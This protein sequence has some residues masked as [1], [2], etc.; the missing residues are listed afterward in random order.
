FD[1]YKRSKPYNPALKVPTRDHPLVFNMLGELKEKDSLVM[2]YKD[3]YEYIRSVIHSRSMSDDL[4]NNIYDAE[5]FIFLGMPFDKWY[6]HLFMHLLHQH[7]KGRTPKF[8]ANTFLDEKIGTL[9]DEQYMM[10][11]VPKEIDIEVFVRTLYEK[12]AEYGMLRGNGTQPQVELPKPALP[13]GQLREWIIGNDFDSLF[14]F[15]VRRLTDTE[16][17]DECDKLEGQY[18][19]LL[20]RQRRGTLSQEQE[21]LERNRIRDAIFDFV[22]LL[23]K[24]FDDSPA[25]MIPN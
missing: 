10:T 3:Y 1:S 17:L 14:D 4:E 6:V 24:H 18:Q 20:R 16:W 7:M 11:F 12:C 21:T 25:V 23:Q 9:C 5:Y 2:T 13:F 22:R 19:D 8:S 15:L